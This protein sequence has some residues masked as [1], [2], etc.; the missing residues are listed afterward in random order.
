MQAGKQVKR[1]YITYICSNCKS[2]VKTYA[3]QVAVE[4]GDNGQCYK[5]C[6]YPVYGPPTPARLLRL[7]GSDRDIFLKGRRCENHGLGIGAFTYYRRVVENHKNRILDEIIRVSNRIG[8]PQDVLNV[9][10]AAKKEIQFSKAIEQIKEAIP[11]S[12]LINGHNPLALLHRP[13]SVGVHEL[14]DQQCLE[15]AHD[16]RVVLVALAERLGQALKDEAE[17]NTAI[18]RLMKA[19]QDK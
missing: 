2:S 15:F 7:F 8:A 12:L 14:T 9:L 10:E 4:N 19:K 18:A 3:M 17:L 16:I 6:E 13:L 1:T 5:F 11:E